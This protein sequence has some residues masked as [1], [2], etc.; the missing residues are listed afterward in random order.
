[1]KK[2]IGFS[3]FIA[4]VSIFAC[5][6]DLD[7]ATNEAFTPTGVE[8]WF[9]SPLRVRESGNKMQIATTN[10]PIGVTESIWKR[11]V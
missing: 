7:E 9:N 3:I 6:R 5:N 2:T 4:L 8:A 10:N 1:M 11:T